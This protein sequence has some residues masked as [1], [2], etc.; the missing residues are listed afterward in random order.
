MV[1]PNLVSHHRPE[2]ILSS[3]L[4]VLALSV[5][6]AGQTLPAQ[7]AH[8]PAYSE[9]FSTYVHKAGSPE[10]TVCVGDKLDVRAIV[11]KE[12]RGGASNEPGPDLSVLYGV[13]LAASVSDPNI[14]TISPPALVTSL[15]TDRAGEAR[16]TFTAKKAGDTTITV[17]AF[18]TTKQALSALTVTGHLP[19]TVKQCL[20]RVTVNAI[21]HMPQ[22]ITLMAKITDAGLP[23]LPLYTDVYSG[24]ADVKWVAATKPLASCYVIHHA[25]ESHATMFGSMLGDLLELKITFHGTPA[26]SAT[27][28]CPHLT[29]T[30]WASQML[31]PETLHVFVPEYGG[32]ASAQPGLL[33]ADPVTKQATITVFPETAP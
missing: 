3:L 25:E 19:V 5:G 32:T 33:G 9:T 31:F 28:I 14:G 22:N 7:A 29:G 4:F 8:S 21:W 1:K 17:D 6:A 27:E 2:L 26:L 13:P 16:L 20:Y 24:D 23:Y 12:V 30:L 18:L 15:D 11:F 10:R